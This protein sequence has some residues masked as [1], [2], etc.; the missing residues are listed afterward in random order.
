MSLGD[1]IRAL[2]QKRRMSQQELAR[3]A[4]I[5]QAV[6]S[7]LENGIQTGSKF[8]S[9]IA[10]ALGVTMGDLDPKFAG[11]KYDLPD[12]PDD[13]RLWIAIEAAFWQLLGSEAKAQDLIAEI[14]QSLK[15]PI[16]PVHGVTEAD[17]LRVT[18]KVAAQRMAHS[19]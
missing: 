5:T 18:V 4:G 17:M 10:N 2:R 14:F 1:N 13:A 9:Q 11:R 19:N 15:K 16:E 3:A 7:D 8:L 12:D 6:I